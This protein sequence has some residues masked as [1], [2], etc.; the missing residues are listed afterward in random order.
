MLF[1]QP[2]RPHACGEN[3]LYNH[4]FQCNLRH[5]R[6]LRNL[7]LIFLIQ[8]DNLYENHLAG[9]ETC[10]TSGGFP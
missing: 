1:A 8:M 6:H 3:D 7:R 4:P 9:L 5:L 2:V 10:P